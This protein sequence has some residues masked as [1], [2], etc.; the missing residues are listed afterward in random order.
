[1]LTVRAVDGDRG[2][3]NEIRYGIVG[4]NANLFGINPLTGL[5]YTKVQSLCDQSYFGTLLNLTYRHI[6]DT[7]YRIFKLIP[8]RYFILYFSFVTKVYNISIKQTH[9]YTFYVH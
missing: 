4:G 9:W 5:I 2:I 6:M 8:K 3:R 1:M 7:V